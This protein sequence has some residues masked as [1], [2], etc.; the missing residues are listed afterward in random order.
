MRSRHTRRLL[1]AVIAAVLV[2]SGSPAQARPPG[3]G[4]PA[5]RPGTVLRPPA[6]KGR[7]VP[8]T[9]PGPAKV[10]PSVARPAPAEAMPA[11]R[12]VRELADRRTATT[13]VFQLADGRTQAEVSREPVHY[14]DGKG[15]WQDIQPEVTAATTAGFPYAAT[16]NSFVSR[17][18]DRSDRVLSYSTGGHGLTLGLAGDR[19][20]LRPT[21]KGTR[22][23]Y[24]D[25]AGDADLVYEVTRSAVKEQIVLAAP[26]SGPATW[27]F[28]LDVDKVRPVPQPDGSVSFHATD[29]EGPALFTMPRPYMYDSADDPDSVVGKKVSYR[30]SQRVGQ[31]AGRTTVTVTAD[32]DWLRSKDRKYPVVIDPTIKVQPTLSQA[33][34]VMLASGGPDE[35]FDSTWKLSAGASTGGTFRSLTKFDLSKVPANTVLDSAQL[36][37]YFDQTHGG[38]D[39]ASMNFEARRVTSAWTENTATWNSMGSKFAEVGENR[40]QVDE[41]DT[42]KVTASGE[43]PGA[44]GTDR[45]Q[46]LNGAYRYNA[47]ATTGQTFTWVPRLTETGQYEVFVHYVPGSNRATNAPYTVYYDGGSV[48]KPVNQ[49]TGSGNGSWVS[50]G[51]YAFK[52][53]TTHKVVLGDVANKT[54]VADGVRFVKRAE[55]NKPLHQ[56]NAW[57]SY[58]VR[59]IVQGWLADQSTN[60]GFMIKGTDE[61]NKGGGPR[62]ESGDFS[63]GGEDDHGPKLVLTWGRPGVALNP[64]NTVRATGA[65]LSWSTYADPSSS[66][67]DDLL[68][69]QVHASRT[70]NFMPSA[71]T[72]VAPVRPGR[73]TYSDTHA[74][75]TPANSASQ[76][77]DAYFYM[78]AA[79]LRDGTVLPAQTQMV[80]LPKAGQVIKFFTGADDNTLTSAKPTSNWDKLDAGGEL[81]VGNKGSIYGTSR[82]V[83]KFPTVTGLPAK[84]KVINAQVGLW[85]WYTEGA[86]IGQQQ[87]Q[88]RGLT[89]DFS[90]TTS[91][92]NSA[93]S[94]VA[95]TT[96]GG[97]AEST[98]QSTV[99]S[100]NGDPGWTNWEAG[101]LVQ[102]WIDTPSTNK[103]VLIRQA[104]EAG[105][106][107]RM[108][109][110]SAEAAEP[111]LR[112]RLR[113][114]FTAPNSESTY[115]AP[116]TP[117]RMI[118]GDQYL[119]PVTVTNTTAS[120]WSPSDWVLSYHWTR[121][122]GT[123]VTTAGNQ[124]ETPLPSA[125]APGGVVTINGTVKAPTSG[126]DGDRREPYVLKWELR[127]KTTGQWLS[128]SAQIDPLDQSVAV[129]DPT[130]DQLG[131]EKFYQYTGGSAG[132]GASLMVNQFS[133]NAVVG[134]NP[135]AN[136]SRGVSTFV[137]LTYNSQDTSTSSM[138]QGW[139]L[140]TSSTVRLGSPLQFRGGD[141]TWP[142][143]VAMTDGDGTTHLFNL[144]KHGSGNPADWRYV[145][146]AGVHLYLQR[147]NSGDTSQAWTMTRPDR[148]Q[149]VFDEQGYQ[150]A[151]QDRNGNQLLF[152]YERMRVDNR[153]TSVLRYLTDPDNRRTLSLDY[154][155]AGDSYT[156]F[157]NGTKQSLTNLQ[158]PRIIDQV[159]SI[160]D[161]S[162]RTLSFVYSDGGL[163][164]EVTDGSGT[165]EAKVFGFAYDESQGPQNARL[166]RVTD[167]RAANTKIAYNDPGDPFQQ[168]KVNAITDRLN[169]VTYVDYQDPDGSA[170][171]A[172]IT[173]V[174]DPKGRATESMIDGFGRAT[175]IT[176]AKNQATILG[177]DADNNVSRLE[178][179]NGAISTWRFDQVTGYPLEIKDPEANKNNTSGLRMDYRYGLS[180]HTAELT[181]KYSPEG[182]HWNFGYDAVGNL[183]SVTDPKGTATS[184]A[185]DYTS[186]YTYDGVGRMLTGTDANDNLTR[187]ADYD[188][189]GYPKTITDPLTKVTKY[190]YSSIGSVLTVTDPKQHTSTFAYDSLGRPLTRKVPKDAANGVYITTPAPVYD[191]NDNITQETSPTGAVTTAVYDPLDR[192]TTVTSPKDTSTS[193]APT[194]KYEYDQVGNV[195]KLTEPKGVL[196]AADT[197]DYTTVY[198]YDELNRPVEATDALNGRVSIEYDLAGNVVQQNDQR[199]NATPQSTDY[200]AKFT[201]DFN[202][203]IKT[204]IDAKGNTTGVEYDRD[205]NPTVSIDQDGNRAQMTY[206]ERSALTEEKVPY[207]SVSGTTTYRTTKYE[208][209]EVGNLSRQISP[210][211]VEST[212]DPD[213]F[214]TVTLYDALNRVREVQQPYDRDDSEFTTA[215]VTRYSYDDIGNLERISA[216]PSKGQSTRND[217]VQT[218]FDNGWIRTSQDAGWNI[219]TS[220][221]YDD[222]GAQTSRKVTGSSGTPRQMNWTYFPDGKKKSQSDNGA[223]SGTPSKNFAY[224]YDVNAN[225]VKMLDTSTGAAIDAYVVSYDP[226]NRVASVEEKNGSTVKNTT[227]FGYEPND[228]LKKR[229]HDTQIS[230][231]TYEA[232]RDLA[233]EIK[234][235]TSPT[236]PKPKYTRYSYTKRGQTATETKGNGNVV[237][238]D[239]F[240][241]GS[242]QSQVEKKSGGAVVNQHTYEYTANGQKS[243]DVS[244]K[245]NA[246]NR[247]AYVDTTS[248]FTY[249]PQDRVRSVT[250][251]GSG[252]GTESYAHDANSNVVS[253]TVGGLPTTFTYDKNRL[254]T[255]TT[256]GASASYAYD[257]YGRLKTVTAA[258]TTVESYT[259]DG[260][261]H[262]VSNT[263]NPGSKTTTYKYDPLDRQVERTYG[264][265]TTTYAYLGLTGDISAELEG[266]KVVKSYQRGPGGDLLSQVKTNTDNSQED[267]YAG[268][269]GSSDIG[270]I[271]DDKGDGRATYGYTAYGKNDAGQFTGVDK[272]DAGNPENPDKVPYNSYRFQSKRFD[273]STGDYDMGF[274]DYDP[275]INQFLSRDSYNGA[276]DD[277]GLAVDP[278]TGNRYA[279]AGGNPIS[280]VELDGHNWLSDAADEVG[281]FVKDAAS[282]IG[283]DAKGTAEAIAQVGYDTAVGGNPLV[284]KDTSEAAKS[285]GNARG[286][287]LK[288]TLSNPGQAV[289]DWA[290]GLTN[291]VKSG[292]PGKA[293]GHLLF[294]AFSIAA[295]G[296]GG[297]AAKG[298]ARAGAGDVAKG[299]VRTGAGKGA[300]RA[301]GDCL[302]NS[303]VPGTQVLMADGS[304]KAIEDVA[305][306]DL[307]LASSPETGETAAKPV[308]RL[309]E[310]EGQRDLVTVTVDVDGAAGDETADITATAGHPFWVDDEQRYIE[311]RQLL[312]GDQVITDDGRE[313]TVVRTRQRTANAAV[314]N[315]TVEDIHTYYVL[316]GDSPV[317]VHNC[318]PNLQARNDMAAS[319]IRPGRNGKAETSQAGLEYDKHQLNPGQVSPKR[320]LPRVGSKKADLD[321]AGQMLLDDITFHPRGVE[322]PVTG[323]GFNGGTRIV[324]PDG[325][326]AVFD[327]GGAFQYF[328]N[329]RYPG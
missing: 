132:S 59:S 159:K 249:D 273:Q 47:D 326:G 211:G 104:D 192:P 295:G 75:P 92:W 42:A 143:Q 259:Y 121:R 27:S 199:K 290:D 287:A 11:P 237:T 44:T 190:T 141:A 244:H 119:V 305:L 236:D 255:A 317:L 97:D 71:A 145:Q 68:E 112:P 310:G 115:Y 245:Q 131:L 202:H 129:E 220:Y 135:L 80:R 301:G 33:Q 164:R 291:D 99:G 205:G 154:Y 89:R 124:I 212:D 265:K 22:V 84:T 232:E 224:E 262:V 166:T 201:Y 188:P 72:L 257:P 76:F 144:D 85:G 169:K 90:E 209:D 43:W 134:Y 2:A 175:R 28:T 179:A 31:Q 128:Q 36:E 10:L 79:R 288:K 238:T 77:G 260:F 263:K 70:Q 9:P 320:F 126:S 247:T 7:D 206:D 88:L 280:N 266:T 30:V 98:V 107:Q 147:T 23:T 1:A 125:Q 78:V 315:L 233:T 243:K 94:G 157:V 48:V 58:S 207:Q 74:T 274:R 170:S 279:F 8:K 313:L 218:F 223:G 21:V 321:Q 294:D 325:V 83:L 283:S 254:T 117:S 18:G 329:F 60:H 182:R 172:V 116:N 289:Q 61:T 122:D 278:Y 57:H 19:R 250:K 35:N 327:Q 193:D 5:P 146:P 178:E 213:D 242:T 189:V 91:T 196:T 282:A 138:G 299:G 309:I 40:E 216:P 102:R 25:A 86:G 51:S 214:A 12:R 15:R 113:V 256:S 41:A 63:Y 105:A 96:A 183:T 248:T 222:N 270:Q 142:Q 253:Q 230:E 191:K 318:G 109:F 227:T 285:R 55:V 235:M 267:S 127:N 180:G 171:N 272:P 149:F 174:T 198:V 123:D 268:Y 69:Y 311:A 29:R 162:G 87:F 219:T 110:L 165:P 65:D 261:D 151:V 328:G 307:V 277:L 195:V 120:V 52:A 38:A 45:A 208:Y 16:R 67:D 62:Y 20:D 173:T 114:I 303:F 106:E 136:P 46:A 3:D 215:P 264:G 186:S 276:L 308:T 228:L 24:P 252:A 56:T 300:S 37:M 156:A 118:P 14:R 319:G 217:T 225:L 210:R 239:Y 39:D 152:T 231:Y 185:G 286:D 229:T 323:G 111:S 167:P 281:D 101:P 161:V 82:V 241:N 177:W 322:E 155:A 271:T 49:T 203:R 140:S 26:P 293:A 108:L 168:G 6:A 95:W 133:G 184:T 197:L 204:S 296:G 93:Q 226:L 17:F 148:S 221:D 194:T 4:K 316:V 150:S 314:Y 73:T 240:L 54:V 13:K 64:V 187:Y 269:D 200:T 284:D 130:S 100:L 153:D 163:L 81:Q 258:G 103:G 234:N 246:D 302:S 275:G 139:S 298:A 34:D 32:G 50:I 66:T 312:G 160:T 181:D 324:R 176:N 304:T 53:G 292:H 137:R 158:N 306:G 251:T 297:G